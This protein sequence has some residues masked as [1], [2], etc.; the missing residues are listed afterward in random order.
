MV[1]YVQLMEPDRRNDNRA[2]ELGGISRSLKLMSKDF[3]VPILALAQLNRQVEARKSHVPVNSD[4]RES[5]SLEQDADTIMFLQR[6]SLYAAADGQS[7]SP[8]AQ[9]SRL[10]DAYLYLTKNRF[11]SIGKV[12]LSFAG[13]ISTFFSKGQEPFAG[14]A[15]EEQEYA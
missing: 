13:D 7:P 12:D 5:G 9:S 10:D 15:E 4:L 1:D 6:P 8:E 14:S 11:G 2:I 3:N